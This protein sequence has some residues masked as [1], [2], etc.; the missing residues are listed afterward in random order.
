MQTILGTCI[1]I[2]TVI[3]NSSLIQIYRHL[4]PKP[5]IVGRLLLS[6][7]MGVA[8]GCVTFHCTKQKKQKR[9]TR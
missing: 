2:I 1:D 8:F 7:T 4:T 6:R 5:Q 9:K 3:I